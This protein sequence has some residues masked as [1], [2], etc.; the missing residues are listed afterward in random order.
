MTPGLEGICSKML[1]FGYAVIFIIFQEN[2]KII[3]LVRDLHIFEH[4]PSSPGWLWK[5]TTKIG[6]SDSAKFAIDADSHD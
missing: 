6:A 3:L 4:M 1:V 2:L 5:T